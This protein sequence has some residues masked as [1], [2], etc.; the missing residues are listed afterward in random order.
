MI[1]QSVA[2]IPAGERGRSAT[3]RNHLQTSVLDGKATILPGGSVTAPPAV[4]VTFSGA[5]HQFNARTVGHVPY[6]SAQTVAHIKLV[7]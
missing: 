5:V 2:R 7:L 3:N 6:T 4:P 1:A